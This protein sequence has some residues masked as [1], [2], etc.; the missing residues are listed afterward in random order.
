MD[1]DFFN[2]PLTEFLKQNL[3]KYPDGGQI[4]KV[5][6]DLDKKSNQNPLET[7]TRAASFFRRSFR[8]PRTLGLQKCGSYWTPKATPERKSW[9][10]SLARMIWPGC[11]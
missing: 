5:D 7:K 9:H 6:L 3:E 4:L 2:P 11:R 1:S 8:M 10:R